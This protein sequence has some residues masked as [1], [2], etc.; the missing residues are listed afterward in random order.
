MTVANPYQP[1]RLAISEY[2]YD[3]TFKVAAATELTVYTLDADGEVLDTLVY[4][5]DFI[6]EISEV[7]EGGSIQTGSYV[8]AVWTPAAPAGAEIVI[9][10]STPYTQPTDIPVRGG[11]LESA[12]EGALDHLAKQIQ[13]IAYSLDGTVEVDPVAEANLLA[14]AQAA[15]TAAEAAQAAAEEAQAAAE[16]VTTDAIDDLVDTS[17]GHRHDGGDSRKVLV[18]D[19]DVTGITDSH[20]VKRSGAGLAGVGHG[21]Q[22][23][24]SSG[25]FTAPAGV[26]KVYVSLVG[27]GG[28]GAGTADPTGSGSPGGGGGG[29]ILNR[30]YTVVPGNSYTVTIG[31]GGTGG[32]GGA[33][34]D[35]GDTSFD[36]LTAP[37]G[38]K[39]TASAGDGGLGGG[40][41][42]GI[43]YPFDAAAAVT[44]ARV[45]GGAGVI[46]GGHG[47]AESGTDG[48]GGG[49]T[50][51]GAG[52]NGSAA[53][54]NGVAG[55]ANTG[56]GGSGSGESAGANRTGG[57]GGSGVVIV[58]W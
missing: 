49:G 27:G 24:T 50:V 37:G 39:G 5:T 57:A 46:R 58:M 51:F 10:R 17:T 14:Q 54:V 20:F 26:T 48:G 31:A 30:P 28:G 13:Q 44:T 47:A 21:D 9:A 7:T 32:T 34:T 8:M 11:F 55:T 25:T 2:D 52:P 45:T 12:I 40:E 29:A 18:T 43:A 41:V 38:K 6:V 1:S 4:G 56:C 42:S 15:V 3:F 19:L 36:T 35:G 22:I 16:A 33:G 53:G 23:F